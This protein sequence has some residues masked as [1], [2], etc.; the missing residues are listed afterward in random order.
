MN[1]LL[2]KKE[3]KEKEKEA[4]FWKA[5]KKAYIVAYDD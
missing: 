1:F 3:K 4:S 5:Q 2:K